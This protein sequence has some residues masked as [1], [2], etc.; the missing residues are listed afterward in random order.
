M[1]VLTTFPYGMGG[2][3]TD[4]NFQ[5][6]T[7]ADSFQLSSMVLYGII[8]AGAGDCTLTFSGVSQPDNFGIGENLLVTV[9]NGAVDPRWIGFFQPN[10]FNVGGDI[11]V[12]HSIT[13]G[14]T[15]CPALVSND[16]GLIA[17]VLT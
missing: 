9:P 17:A 2:E 1:A 12:Q 6:V 15:V 7:G 8:N 4:G 11:V 5:S 16:S 10:R 3:G 13:A 14:V